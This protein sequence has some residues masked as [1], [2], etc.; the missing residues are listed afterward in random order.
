MLKKS[1]RDA[2]WKSISVLP[3][4][5]RRHVWFAW[6]HRARGDFCNP[7]SFSEKI[8]WRILNDRSE[9]LAWTCDKLAMKEHARDLSPTIS[10]PETIWTG[11]DLEEFSRVNL[12]EKWVLKANHRSKNVF[13]GHGTPDVAALQDET[14]DWLGDWQGNLLGEWAYTQARPV[15]FAETWIGDNV[16]APIDYK[17]FVFDGVP[18]YILVDTGRFSHHRRRFYTADWEPL[19]A[20]SGYGLEGIAPVEPRPEALEEM[21]SHAAALGKG[22]DF[23]RVDLYDVDGQVFFG[24]VTPYPAGGL[25]R[26][27]P[28]EF[29][30]EL[31]KHWK[32]R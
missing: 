18:R 14:S 30:Y 20:R 15:M 11:T 27:L 26:F 2:L 5:Q 25:E 19:D 23:M 24:E 7:T 8:N 13:L 10:I 21:R 17:F 28:V 12:P 6:S 22:F 16:E 4:R 1:V 3:L 29:D 32:L 31:G 9:G